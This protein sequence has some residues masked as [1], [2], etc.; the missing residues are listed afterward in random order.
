VVA[1]VLAGSLVPLAG[2][3]GEHPPAAAGPSGA[4]KVT[5]AGDSIS[6]GLGSRLRT[7]APEGTTV[8]VIG[9]VGTGLARPDRYDWPARMR[10]LARRF[11]PSVLVFSVGSN[12]DQDLTDASGA[13]V[14]ARSDPGWEAEY[15]RRL[16]SVFDA[17][18]GTATTVV[19]GGHVRT[20]DEGVGETNRLVNRLATAAAA[21][22]DWVQVADLGELLGTGDEVATDC[23]LPDGLH[24]STACLDRADRA[25]LP[26][27]EG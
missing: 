13:M 17:F 15:T 1:L 19:W 24:L 14:V 7:M 26:R 22:R 9:E 3:G 25:L 18:K 2:C 6:L 27:L 4:R 23:L 5:V 21:D 16:E 20:A 8:K 11:P 10:D 12:D